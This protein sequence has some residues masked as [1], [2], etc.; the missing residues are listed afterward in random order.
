MQ[1]RDA[2]IGWTEQQRQRNLQSIVT[3]GRFLIL[4]WVRVKGLASKMLAL[5]A[6]QMSHDWQTRYGLRPLL[7]ETLVD[8]VCSRNLLSSRQLDSP[9]ADLRER[10]H[11]SQH[12]KLMGRRPR[13]FTFYPAGT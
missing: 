13:I 3:H 8:A 9:R 6:R 7:F 12:I 4:P 10:S 2:W 1:A 11:G 5:S